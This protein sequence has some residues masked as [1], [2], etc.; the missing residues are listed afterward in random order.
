MMYSQH[1]RLRSHRDY[2][3]V[4]GGASVRTTTLCGLL[5]FFALV[6]TLSAQA[7]RPAVAGASGEARHFSPID[8]SPSVVPVGVRGATLE[9]LYRH[10]RV[11][12]R[13]EF[14]STSDFTARL[15]SGGGSDGVY[16][17]VLSTFDGSESQCGKM[18]SVRYDAD[19]G[20]WR[21][22]TSS[23]LAWYLFSCRDAHMGSYVGVNSFGAHSRVDKIER[24]EVLLA[25]HSAFL[26]SGHRLEGVI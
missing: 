9:D 19:A 12:P 7:G 21:F 5:P 26:A 13:D 1:P 15:Q 6:T 3:T 23:I 14:E 20:G 16:G 11:R 17:F 8:S 10:F 2:C 22:S 25:E 18:P 24:T 4:T